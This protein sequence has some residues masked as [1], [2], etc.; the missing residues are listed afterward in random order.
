MK[1]QL[2]G[3]LCKLVAFHP[4]PFSSQC[5]C[6]PMHSIFLLSCTETVRENKVLKEKNA[7]LQEYINVVTLLLMENSPEL[8]NHELLHP[9]PPQLG[10]TVIDGMVDT[11]EDSD[12]ES[13]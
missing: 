1:R 4:P 10:E 11:D 7:A 3:S 8:L 2:R 6:T 12:V 9:A 5:S 13:V